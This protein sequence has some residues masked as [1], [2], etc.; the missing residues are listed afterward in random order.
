MEIRSITQP[1]NSWGLSRDE[2]IARTRAL[3]AAYPETPLEAIRL[4]SADYTIKNVIHCASKL[5][6]P[7][8]RLDCS[9]SPPRQNTAVSSFACALAIS[10]RA[11]S[12]AS[13]G[14]FQNHLGFLV[15]RNRKLLASRNAISMHL[16]RC[17]SIS[18]TCWIRFSFIRF[19]PH[20]KRVPDKLYLRWQL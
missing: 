17:F 15:S 18:R 3:M 7:A 12:C 13:A 6:M 14:L 11:S 4:F 10:R 19:S 9:F 16:L 2:Y 8:L 5:L 1:D 20:N